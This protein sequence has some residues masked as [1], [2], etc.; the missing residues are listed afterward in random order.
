MERLS[1]RL[2]GSSFCVTSWHWRPLRVAGS[3]SLVTLRFYGPHRGV[4]AGVKLLPKQMSAGCLF[5]QG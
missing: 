5:I 1:E 4:A 2:D 3:R